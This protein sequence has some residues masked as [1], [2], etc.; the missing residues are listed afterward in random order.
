LILLE[1]IQKEKKLREDQLQALN[2]EV[3]KNWYYWR[4]IVYGLVKIDKK[5][6]DAETPLFARKLN[7]AM[8]RRAE[9]EA[10]EAERIKNER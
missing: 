4:P 2:T 8:N 9:L 3:K 6:Y 1:G 5:D 10:Q 7:V